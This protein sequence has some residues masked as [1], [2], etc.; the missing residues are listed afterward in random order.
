MKLLATCLTVFCLTA[1][2]GCASNHATDLPTEVLSDVPACAQGL[3]IEGPRTRANV[4]ANLCP[5]L[6][7]METIYREH[8][9]ANPDLAGSV[10]LR[11][12]VEW[13]GEIG[14]IELLDSTFEDAEFLR[15]LRRPV[16]F[17]DF[18]GWM[19]KDEDTAV[20]CRLVFGR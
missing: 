17:A 5:L 15:A 3:E 6:E 10:T 7:R 2:V 4:V 19:R 8:C 14:V 1:L 9:A 16:E 13:N 18:D 12:E 20:R 11:V